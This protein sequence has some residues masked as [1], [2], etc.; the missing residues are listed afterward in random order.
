[1]LVGG[2]TGDMLRP[3]MWE[4]KYLM[5][6]TTVIVFILS[7]RKNS[8]SECWKSV[9]YHQTFPLISAVLIVSHP[10]FPS[11]HLF[12]MAWYKNSYS[13]L[14]RGITTEYPTCQLYFL[15]THIRLKYAT[16]KHCITSRPSISTV[17]YLYFVYNKALKN[18][19]WS[20]SSWTY[21]IKYAIQYS[22]L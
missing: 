5:D 20:F 9:V 16:R 14:S 18:M 11:G 7:H 10:T 8:Q 17:L 3:I 13:T 22:C 12:S 19:F 2:L 21:F 1:M 4:Q 15:G 6:Y